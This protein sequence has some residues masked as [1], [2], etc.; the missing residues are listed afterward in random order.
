MD[1]FEQIFFDSQG[2]PERIANMCNVAVPTAR[3]KKMDFVRKAQKQGKDIEWRFKEGKFIP[4]GFVGSN[5]IKVPPP[6]FPEYSN[7]QYH[8]EGEEY[9][10]RFAS[11]ADTHLGSKSQRLDWIHDFYEYAG[12]QG[13]KYFLHAGDFVTGLYPQRIFDSFLHAGDD[14]V[15]YT[16]EHY[17]TPPNNGKTIAIAGNHDETFIRVAGIDIMRHIADKRPDIDYLGMMEGIVNL[18]GCKILLQHGAGGMTMNISG[19]LQK[20]IDKLPYTEHRPHAII[21]GHYH[22]GSCFLPDYK[23]VVGILPGSFEGQTLF[24]KK[25]KITPV[26]SGFIVEF[27][28]KNQK[29]IRTKYEVRKYS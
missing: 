3:K 19:K 22:S 17:P 5:E 20:Y 18:D 10:I 12:R 14:F 29:I 16:C 13:I 28:L 23:G 26:N 2:I 6:Y 25:N 1:S 21:L 4:I 11:L 9:T 7:H 24:L 15:E 8:E 27:T